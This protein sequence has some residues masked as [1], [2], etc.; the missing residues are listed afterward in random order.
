M[1]GQ[2][3]NFILLQGNC[4]ECRYITYMMHTDLEVWK[5]SLKLA[6]S[7]YKLTNNLPKDERYGI[8]SQMKRAAVSVP[9]NIAEGAAKRSTKEYLRYLEISYASLSELHTYFAIL[10]EFEWF[11]PEEIP[12]SELDQI[13]K[14]HYRLQQSLKKF[15]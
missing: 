6:K 13:Q 9:A 8:S 4:S 10:E 11:R 15:L 14:M 2:T 12:H 3:V 1:M 7:V 5:R